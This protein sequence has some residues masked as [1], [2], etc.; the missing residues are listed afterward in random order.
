MVISLAIAGISISGIV[1]GYIFSSREMEETA[2]SNAAEAMARQR[3][4][5]ARSAK[6]DTLAYPPV[7]ELVGNNFPVLISTLDIPVRA[8]N[9]LYATC[10]TTIATA[11]EA[12]PLRMI[13]VDAVW[14]L[15]PRGPFT[16]TITAY[17]APDQ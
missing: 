11:S 6:W 4:E 1:T 7:D 14:S 16:N 9:P 17:R 8:N 15:P 12:P 10:T 2:C 5:Q 3:V 13:R